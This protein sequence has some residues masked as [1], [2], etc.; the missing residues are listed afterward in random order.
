MD[1]FADVCV[2]FCHQGSG[3]EPFSSLGVTDWEHKREV[4]VGAMGRS[5]DCLELF[6]RIDL[7]IL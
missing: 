3:A 5:T 4:C 2:C 1:T 6:L 7:T